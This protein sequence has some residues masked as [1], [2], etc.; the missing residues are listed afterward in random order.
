MAAPAQAAEESVRRRPQASSLLSAEGLLSIVVL[1]GEQRGC[2]L[3]VS[4][5]AESKFSTWILPALP[6]LPCS[7]HNSTMEMSIGA[8]QEGGLAWFSA[9]HVCVCMYIELVSSPAKRPSLELWALTL[10]NV[11]P[12]SEGLPSH[13]SG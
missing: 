10:R 13:P 7:F 9:C 6:K 1:H 8:L 12:S 4:S 11:C 2:Y 5:K 3:L